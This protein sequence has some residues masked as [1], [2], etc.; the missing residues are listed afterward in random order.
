MARIGIGTYNTLY[1]YQPG[2]HFIFGQPVIIETKLF[3]QD[4]K[5]SPEY[6]CK[7]NPGWQRILA[8][9]NSLEQLTLFTGKY[10]SGSEKIIYRAAEDFQDKKEILQFI[11][12]P[13]ELE[14]KRALIKNLGFDT[15]QIREFKDYNYPCEESPILLGYAIDFLFKH[16]T[17]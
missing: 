6:V 2:V 4:G 7:D 12:C 14:E 15:N 10:E 16:P 5:K 8:C 3:T 13:H 9:K 1:S 17:L 11:L